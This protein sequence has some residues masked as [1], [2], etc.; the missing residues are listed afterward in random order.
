[1]C[2]RRPRTVRTI[3]FL[4]RSIYN[5]STNH[6]FY[7]WPHRKSV[8]KVFW[9]RNPFTPFVWRRPRTV[10]TI[11]F[12]RG[13]GVVCAQ[14][15]FRVGVCGVFFFGSFLLDKQKKWTKVQLKTRTQFYYNIYSAN[16]H[17]DYSSTHSK[18]TFSFLYAPDSYRDDL[19]VL[20]YEEKRTKNPIEKTKAKL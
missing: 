14:R 13:A 16:Q 7:D 17:V 20:F 4:N 19:L 5:S 2:A 1:M 6:A 9:A 3:N 12:L 10:R 11:N 8:K 18:K 15:K